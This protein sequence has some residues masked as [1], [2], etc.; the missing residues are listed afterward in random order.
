M[1]TKVMRSASSEDIRGVA[2]RAMRTREG[3][4]RLRGFVLVV[5]A[6]L[7]ADHGSLVLVG[8]SP[9]GCTIW[10]RPGRGNRDCR[11]RLRA[12]TVVDGPRP[13]LGSALGPGAE[14]TGSV[15]GSG[16]RD[17]DLPLVS[18]AR[19]AGPPVGRTG[20][21]GP[22]QRGATPTGSDRVAVFPKVDVAGPDPSGA[23]AQAPGR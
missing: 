11:I 19:R 17:D 5:S 7:S 10:R 18:L 20:L 21:T 1:L 14:A 12:V 8:S 13:S 22:R 4:G 15:S 16:T 3:K 23:E 9:S 2:R 6:P